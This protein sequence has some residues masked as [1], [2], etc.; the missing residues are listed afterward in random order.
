[1]VRLALLSTGQFVKMIIAGLAENSQLL[2]VRGRELF[3]TVP[4]N[5]LQAEIFARR[6]LRQFGKMRIHDL[7]N[8]GKMVCQGAIGHHH[9]QM[10]IGQQ[11]YS[12]EIGRRRHQFAWFF[13]LQGCALEVV[14]PSP[15][16]RMQRKAFFF[17]LLLRHIRQEVIVAIPDHENF[18]GMAIDIPVAG[19]PGKRLHIVAGADHAAYIQIGFAELQLLVLFH[20]AT[21]ADCRRASTPFIDR[22]RSKASV[23]GEIS[24]RSMA[25]GRKMQDG[26]FADDYRLPERKELVIKHRRKIGA[27]NSNK[28]I[29]FEKDLG[30]VIM[31]LEHTSR[32]FIT[33][34]HIGHA[35]G[36]AVHS[37]ARTC[38][39]LRETRMS[40]AL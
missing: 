11:A 35:C 4:V 10:T 18:M 7:T 21:F 22:G 19:L 12:A 30:T 37:A 23:C 14:T 25:V 3:R 27:R 40:G 1:M 5:Q 2:P 9:L 26:A 34:K 33:S 15:G 36:I 32:C 28:R 24:K 17:Q 8:A 38:A 31:H 6:H 16:R 39:L 29:L 13:Q 20:F